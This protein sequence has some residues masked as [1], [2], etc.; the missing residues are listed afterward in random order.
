MPS[1]FK[2]NKFSVTMKRFLFDAEFLNSLTALEIPLSSFLMYRL[3]QF[4]Q[5]V[6]FLLEKC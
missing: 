1:S 5:N 6:V 3:L 2:Q 4:A